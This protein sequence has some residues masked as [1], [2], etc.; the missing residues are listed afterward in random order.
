MAEPG[1]DRDDELETVFA[2][3]GDKD[4]QMV[5]SFPGA[6]APGERR[7]RGQFD[8][9]SGVSGPPEYSCS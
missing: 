1:H 8:D 6:L 2:L 5:G 3:V 9:S 4:T 7:W